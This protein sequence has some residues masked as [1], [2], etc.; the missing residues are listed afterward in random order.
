M[1][2]TTIFKQHLWCWWHWG[3][4]SRNERQ[5]ELFFCVLTSSIFH[6][7]DLRLRGSSVFVCETTLV[8]GELRL[9]R[10]LRE[11][12][13]DM[14]G[15]LGDEFLSAFCLYLVRANFSPPWN[16][17]QIGVKD[18]V[19]IFTFIALC[20]MMKPFHILIHSS[21]HSFFK[22][23]RVLSNTTCQ[24]QHDIVNTFVF[25]WFFS[26]AFCCFRKW[27]F[28]FFSADKLDYLTCV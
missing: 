19:N 9:V 4:E 27:N 7:C 6:K 8:L 25:D 20:Q 13:D 1:K 22:L 14:R 15:G 23:S 5:W 17:W 24:N 3:E 26:H 16:E 11:V 18:P 2:I 10:R 28:S 21:M 12:V